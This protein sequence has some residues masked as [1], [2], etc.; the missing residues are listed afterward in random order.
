MTVVAALGL[1]AAALPGPAAAGGSVIDHCYIVCD[2]VDPDTAVYEDANGVIRH[3]NGV[4][5]VARASGN[6]A[7]VQLRYSNSCRMA[8]A[9]G[10]QGSEIKVE[11]FDATGRVLRIAYPSIGSTQSP[12]HYTLA[13]N[14]AGLLAR[15]C[16]A[17][18]PSN[19]SCTRKY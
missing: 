6:A 14:D 4:H 12:T 16:I 7:T 17:V 18:G 5:T 13:V 9:K 10:P 8:W 2:G 19:W 15:A 1:G 3:C 11:G